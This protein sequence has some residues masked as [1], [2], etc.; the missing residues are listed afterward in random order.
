[1]EKDKGNTPKGAGGR[2]KVKANVSLLLMG[3]DGK[4]KDKRTI[5]NIIVDAG[6]NDVIKQI[7]GDTGGGAQ[8]AKFN[9][10]G[11]GTSATAPA[12]GDTALGAEIGTRVQDADPA[13]PATGQGKIET[14]FLAGNGTG[15][16]VECGLLN[17]VSAGTLLARTTFTV[18][19]KGALDILLVTWTISLT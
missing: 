6:F 11:V 18:I 9:Y 16:I 1:V 5:K 2:I 19:N 14:T 8:P 4:E 3:P 7:L 13:F 15:A 10:V 17:A 12:V